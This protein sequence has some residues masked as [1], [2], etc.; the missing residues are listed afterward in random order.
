MYFTHQRTVYLPVISLPASQR[1]PK[2][3][4]VHLPVISVYFTH[5]RIVHLPVISLPA[6][7][8]YP[9]YRTSTLLL[10]LENIDKTYRTLNYTRIKRR[11]RPPQKKIRIFYAPRFFSGQTRKKRAQITRVNTVYYYRMSQRM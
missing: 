8:R 4:T 2:Y 1:Y 6:S 10:V 5:H 9:K 7:Q 11:S 3:R